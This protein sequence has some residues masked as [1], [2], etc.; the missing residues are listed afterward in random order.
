MSRIKLLAK[1]RLTIV[2]VMAI[3]IIRGVQPLQYRGKPM[4]HYNGEDNA[5]HYG[6]KGP[7]NFFALAA[8]HYKKKTD[9]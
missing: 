8:M 1:S 2:E 3:F 5:S 7:D 6:R 4:W 9:P